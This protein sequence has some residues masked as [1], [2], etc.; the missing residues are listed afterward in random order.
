MPW[1]RNT[2]PPLL[3]LNLN[4]LP[5]APLFVY[6]SKVSKAYMGAR[7][8]YRPHAFGRVMAVPQSCT[9]A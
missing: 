7:A 8:G 5:D 6:D 2:Q 3:K 9:E 1:P 4:Q